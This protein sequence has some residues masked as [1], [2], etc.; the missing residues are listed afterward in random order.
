MQLLLPCVVDYTFTL[1]YR[2]FF[3]FF[4]RSFIPNVHSF[5]EQ[6]AENCFKTTTRFYKR[7]YKKASFQNLNLRTVIYN[8]FQKH[9]K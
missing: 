4:L 8:L 3:S 6:Q 9:K 5:Y 2:A 7:I 1:K